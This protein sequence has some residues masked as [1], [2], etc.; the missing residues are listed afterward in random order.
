MA[1]APRI[2]V[3][4]SSTVTEGDRAYRDALE[5]GAE[6]ARSGAVVMT[7][8]YAGTM[9]AASRGA[10]E[11][12]GHVIGVTIDFDPPRFPNRWVEERLH[13]PDLFERLRLL[14]LS[15]DGFVA[16]APS[17]GTYTEVCLAWTLL[18]L[19]ARRRAPLVLLGE[20]WPAWLD[21]MR[22]TGDM[23]GE[24]VEH[25]ALAATPGEAARLVLAGAG[26]ATR[27]GRS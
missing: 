25:V 19:G 10:R 13:A 6:L 22:G 15:A 20:S 21:A 16:V 18:S 11:A 1:A 26:V 12:G 5:L 8:G 23:T 14:I 7:G 3:Y 2:A 24:L 17:L 9:E 4:G 27:G